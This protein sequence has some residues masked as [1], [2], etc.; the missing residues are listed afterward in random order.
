MEDGMDKADP[1][2]TSGVLDLSKAEAPRDQKPQTGSGRLEV[3]CPNCHTPMDVAVD[4]LLTDLTC[5]V[6]GSHFSL[7]DQSQPTR[8][9]PPLSTMGRFELIERLGVGGFGSVWKAR[10]REL[11]RTVA[12]KI[13][14]QGG[15]TAEQQEKF[16]REAR[17]AAQLR[18]PSI[19]SVHEV[20]RDGENVY[21]VSD[22]VRGVTLGDWL[23]GQK[24]TSREAA[25]LCARIADALHHA[26]EQG[27]VHRDLKP[28]N[29][30]IDGAGEPHLMDFGLARR[31]V[32][33]VTVTVDGEVLGTP[34][35]MSPEQ[36][37]G[38][39]HT[40]D[41]R[42]DVYSLGVILF[43][44]LTGELPF[45]GNARM[46]MHQVI[47]DE[48]PS[49][50]KLNANV[51]DDLETITLKCLEK[52]PARRYATSRESAEDLRRFLAGE[53]IQARPISRSERAARWVRRNPVVS[54]LSAAV[55]VALLVG[56][57]VSVYFAQGARRKAALALAREQEANV[58]RRDA[59]QR[60]KEAEQARSEESQAKREAEAVNRFLVNMYGNFH[61][62]DGRALTVVEVLDVAEKQLD[63]D[64]A[65]QP[66]T[67]AAV[68]LAIGGAR[69][70][71]GQQQRAID[72]LE[73]AT[74]IRRKI[75][76]I[77]HLDT[78]RAMT[79]LAGGY[80]LV[81]A[82]HSIELLKQVIPSLRQKLGIDHIETTAAM[83]QL[84]TI[85][86]R[87]GR[88]DDAVKL[89]KEWVSAR[90][91]K[92]G[93][94]DSFVPWWLLSA[95]GGA[96]RLDEAIDHLEEA[97]AAKRQRAMNE[98][99]TY[100]LVNMLASAYRDA[101]REDDAYRVQED[102]LSEL[103]EKLGIDN[104]YTQAAIY[105]LCGS[106]RNAGRLDDEIRLVEKLLRTSQQK[107]GSN[108]PATFVMMQQLAGI[109]RVA[110][111]VDEQINLLEQ[112]RAL[113]PKKLEGLYSP[114]VTIDDLSQAY[115]D[116]GRLTEAVA[117]R[118]E[119]LVETRKESAIEHPD[120][121]WAIAK[122]VDTYRAAGR[123]D[124]AVEL[125]VET[126]AAIR[127]KLGLDH[128]QTLIASGNLGLV[129]RQAGRLD[130]AIEIWEQDLPKIQQKIGLHHG[131]TFTVVDNLVG[132]YLA[133]KRTD[134]AIRLRQQMV[135]TNR[136]IQGADEAATD[137]AVNK[138]A[139]L[140][141][142]TGQ[143]DDAIRLGEETIAARLTKRGADHYST[144]DAA[145]E[146]IRAYR[147]AGDLDKAG[148]LYKKQVLNHG[149]LFD[150][151]QIATPDVANE[152]M[153]FAS[154][155][156]QLETGQN[157]QVIDLVVLGELK[158][159]QG[160]A[161]GAEAAIRAGL[162]LEA[163][164]GRKSPAFM[165]K[166][167][168]WCL[169]AQGR[170]GEAKQAFERSLS[171]RKRKDGTFN[172]EGADYVQMTSAYFLDLITEEQYIAH[173]A[174]DEAN[175]C[176]PWL[177]VGQR[178]EIEGNREAAIAAYEKCV[179]LGDDET[180]HSNRA[181]ARWRLAKLRESA[182]K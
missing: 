17:A 140:Y 55:L 58:A 151:L 38:E 119:V 162:G 97:L 130:E 154:V 117:L 164:N 109:Y 94:N 70:L 128:P 51:S 153:D 120:S 124:R 27:V 167:L 123:M 141:R 136:E 74:E 59:E 105:N 112:L 8:M 156:N 64:F 11:D 177:Y 31:D 98:D 54:A 161:K 5:S 7:V 138:L 82:D 62:D 147:A 180:A 144:I 20:G 84:A 90:R 47:H 28:A 79:A 10:D 158:L 168:G 85:Y 133:A 166:S 39:S 61:G 24:P 111:R 63:I 4:T 171:Y 102:F 56:T 135:E 18:H 174:R 173:T 116:S 108:H 152:L 80:E 165:D 91:Q 14:R 45:R 182:D 65:D 21:I 88:W 93:A 15:M 75:L 89:H 72:A 32:G 150:G 131:V 35:Y 3:R 34:A 44:L 118:E 114:S 60:Q 69:Q 155:H 159:V 57:I 121:Q 71:L 50:R 49:P 37:V 83:H 113:A 127:E 19:V 181:L 142:E 42:S 52:E 40:A 76:G 30:M 104:A 160:D 101:G 73:K 179:R 107:L 48:P 145:R 132:A 92:L 149:Y 96:G 95:Y 26:H 172:L 176:F 67:Q 126:L 115:L 157:W 6:C 148:A 68:L 178:R 143:L 9:A 103:Q 134:D 2:T 86:G 81:R 99:E 36:A 100:L 1:S 12:I 87:E 66:L 23:T 169:L 29:I 22:F 77:D 13:P 122:L 46:I 78:L 175:A 170:A 146:L 43:Q 125:R 129:Y 53:P 139:R 163:M 33:E 137:D 110:G 16:F 41:R 106:Y 25:E